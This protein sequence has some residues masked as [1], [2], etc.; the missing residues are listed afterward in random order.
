MKETLTY[1]IIISI[2][3]VILI[4]I[5]LKYESITINY[6]NA[7][8]GN[9]TKTEESNSMLNDKEFTNEAMLTASQGSSSLMI[10]KVIKCFSNLGIPS[11][12]AVCK[13]VLDNVLPSEFTITVLGNKSTPSLFQGSINGT[14]VSL[15]PGKYTVSENLFDTKNIE[16]Q[17]GEATTGS[18]STTALGDCNGQF[19]YLDDFQNATGTMVSGGNQRCDI[20]NTIKIT[21]GTISQEP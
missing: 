16:N 14:V 2:A 10:T 12:E 11:N 20:I 3:L 4:S 13:F 8:N 18:V 9:Y 7:Q 21:A 6:V 15:Q 5:S 19:N 17:L 1:S